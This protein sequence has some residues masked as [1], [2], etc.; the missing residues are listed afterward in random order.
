MSLWPTRRFPASAP[1]AGMA[2]REAAPG[3]G[4]AVVGLFRGRRS[5]S[6]NFIQ[7]PFECIGPCQLNLAVI[8]EAKSLITVSCKFGHSHCSCRQFAVSIKML[9]PNCARCIFPHE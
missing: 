5:L 7:I 8:S 2:L 1:D 6:V 4:E 9:S 3:C